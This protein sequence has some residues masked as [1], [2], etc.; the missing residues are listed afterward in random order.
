MSYGVLLHHFPLNE[1][2]H[3]II[4]KVHRL[5]G[6]ETV[7]HLSSNVS[8]FNLAAGKTY[9]LFRLIHF[10]DKENQS[11][12]WSMSLISN[13]KVIIVVSTKIL[14]T[15]ENSLFMGRLSVSSIVP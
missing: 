10:H 12:S 2:D 7:Q 1:N 11:W 8:S 9:H 15:T 3:F 13:S 14:I 6:L 4:M 5:Q